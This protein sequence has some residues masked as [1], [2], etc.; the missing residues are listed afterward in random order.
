MLKSKNMVS[1]LGRSSAIWTSRT[2][3][4][5]SWDCVMTFTFLS[6]RRRHRAAPGIV[7]FQWLDCMTVTLCRAALF[8]CDRIVAALTASDE[9]VA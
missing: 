7:G 3:R 6:A 8:A 4:L 9:F 2:S 1:R 5:S